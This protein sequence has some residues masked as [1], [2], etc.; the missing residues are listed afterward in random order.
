MIYLGDFR[1]KIKCISN[2]IYYT[3]RFVFVNRNLSLY[4]IKNSYLV[5][6]LAVN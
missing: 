5:V 1:H 4:Q 6:Y 3:H 2:I